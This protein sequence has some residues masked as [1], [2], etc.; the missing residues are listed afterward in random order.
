MRRELERA[1]ADAQARE[2]RQTC[3][4]IGGP[5]RGLLQDRR[6][7]H[8]L[9]RLSIGM[10]VFPDD[11]QSAERLLMCAEAAMYRMKDEDRNGFRFYT[12]EMQAKALLRWR[13]PELGAISPQESPAW[14]GLAG[15]RRTASNSS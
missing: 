10:A 9:L 11:G 7:E 1:G 13:P 4:I 14:L 2:I 3:T 5:L 15:C 8:D 6:Q 12:P